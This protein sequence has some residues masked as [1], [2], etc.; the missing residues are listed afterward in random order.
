MNKPAESL[1]WRA[2]KSRR[3]PPVTGNTAG[4]GSGV[5]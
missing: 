5:G 3:A 1:A 2:A 4:V